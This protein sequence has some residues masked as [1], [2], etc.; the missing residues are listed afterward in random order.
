MTEVVN[1]QPRAEEKHPSNIEHHNFGYGEILRYKAENTRIDPSTGEK[2][3][4]LLFVQG[5]NGDGKLP[6]TL[7]KL[8]K[9]QQRDIIA[10]RYKDKLK[11][12]ASTLET[13]PPSDNPEEQLRD[14]ASDK[15]LY[16]QLPDSV[17]TEMDAWQADEIAKA[18]DVLDIQ[19]V[20][21]VAESRGA[22]RLMT[23]MLKNPDLFRHIYLAH[24]A[25]LDG[26]NYSQSHFDAV[27]QFVHHAIRK[28]KVEKHDTAGTSFS[29]ERR[30]MRDPRG[31]RKEQKSVAHAE[32]RTALYSLATAHP[33][34][35]F[36][37][38]GDENDRA[39]LADRLAANAESHD[40]IHFVR[41][42]WGGHGIGQNPQAIKEISSGLFATETEI[43]GV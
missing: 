12:S 9:E 3:Q 20:D 27:K 26:R 32:L 4:P 18:L 25:G 38:A 7:E 37:I 22:I 23:A 17:V 35:Q 34:K 39:F 11:G 15:P 43:K 30:W 31:W 24:P 42:D 28:R 2:V 6:W 29:K 14:I 10:V 8:A 21:A 1:G 33:D 13:L 40:N 16:E 19:Q 5:I 36:I 41:T